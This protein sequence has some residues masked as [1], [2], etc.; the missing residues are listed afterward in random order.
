[1][2]RLRLE[3]CIF[4]IPQQRTTDQDSS[5]PAGGPSSSIERWFRAYWSSDNLHRPSC[6]FESCNS[7]LILQLP[8]GPGFGPVGVD[9]QSTHHGL[10]SGYR[11]SPDICISSGVRLF[12]RPPQLPLVFTRWIRSRCNATSA[13]RVIQR[14][15][16]QIHIDWSKSSPWGMK[17]T[18]LDPVG[19]Y[20]A[21]QDVGR[22]Y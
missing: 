11:A 13:E 3:A 21:V 8:S 17:L 9:Q 15:S 6:H 2:H 16:D 12:T 20:D 10:R 1:M 19:A 7:D 14:N 22:I 4:F 18:S 5:G